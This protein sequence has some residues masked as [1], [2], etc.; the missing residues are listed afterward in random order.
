MRRSGA[1]FPIVLALGAISLVPVAGAQERD[2]RQEKRHA[3]TIFEAEPSR[4]RGDMLISRRIS[5]IASAP[6]PSAPP[7]IVS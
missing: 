1:L 7:G 4:A 2:F 5:A 3:K 6:R